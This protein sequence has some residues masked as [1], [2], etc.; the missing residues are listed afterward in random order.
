MKRVVIL[1]LLIGLSVGLNNSGDW[2]G[3]FSEDRSLNVDPSYSQVEKDY[4]DK[5]EKDYICHHQKRRQSVPHI[6]AEKLLDSQDLLSRIYFHNYRFTGKL[7]GFTDVYHFIIMKTYY[8]FH[9]G[10][11]SIETATYVQ[12]RQSQNQEKNN[13]IYS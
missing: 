10:G 2:S 4:N 5:V 12:S 1:V 3:S 9:A 6:P 7:S 13:Q 8:Y 11:Y